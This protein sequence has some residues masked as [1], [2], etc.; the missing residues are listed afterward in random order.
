MENLYELKIEKYFQVMQYQDWSIALFISSN[1][2]VQ[3]SERNGR[4]AEWQHFILKWGT[5][6]LKIGQEA[7]Y[8]IPFC[9][10]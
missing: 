3:E 2:Y 10:F 7:N 5:W 9:S 8:S 6:I 1:I 4:M